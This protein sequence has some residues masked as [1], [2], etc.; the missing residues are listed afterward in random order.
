VV[1]FARESLVQFASE[2]SSIQKTLITALKRS[3]FLL[4]QPE[5]KIS[6]KIS[7][8]VWGQLLKK[9][10]ASFNKEIR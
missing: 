2:Y 9:E 5:K 6:P 4:E 8:S 1:Q 3:L 7:T 10:K